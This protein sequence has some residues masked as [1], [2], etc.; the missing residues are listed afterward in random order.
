MSYWRMPAYNLLRLLVTI[1]LGLALG[2]LY[3]GRGDNRWGRVEG[4]REVEGREVEGREGYSIPE[5]QSTSGGTGGA[6][7]ETRT[8]TS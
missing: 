5:L 8:T 6:E 3:W 4:G 1:A 2:T 7:S